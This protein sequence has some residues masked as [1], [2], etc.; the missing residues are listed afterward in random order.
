MRI[1]RAILFGSRARGD[2]LAHSDYDLLI[3]S[4]DFGGQPFYARAA[5]LLLLWDRPQDLELLCYTPEEFEAKRRGLNI[6]ATAASE[7]VDLALA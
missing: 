7:G 6:A 4:P 2:A 1:E 3:V 5:P